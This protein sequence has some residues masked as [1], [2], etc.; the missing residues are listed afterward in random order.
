[1]FFQIYD[2][3][4]NKKINPMFYENLRDC[5]PHDV[6]FDYSPALGL[7]D[8]EMDRTLTIKGKNIGKVVEYFIEQ[9][10]ETIGLPNGIKGPGLLDRLKGYKKPNMRMIIETYE[11]FEKHLHEVVPHPNGGF[12]NG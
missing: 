3:I 1:M 12:V 10:K 8:Y 9:T 5:Q 7:F 4:F 6:R 2:P 11:E